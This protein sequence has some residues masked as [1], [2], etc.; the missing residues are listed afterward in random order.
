ME[1][2]GFNP[3]IP[4]DADGSGLPVAVLTYE[5]TAQS[6]K[7]GKIMKLIGGILMI[8]MGLLLVFKPEWV[9]LNF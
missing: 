6:T 2:K 4:G 8:I 9:M 1:V 7:Y 5:V 3:L